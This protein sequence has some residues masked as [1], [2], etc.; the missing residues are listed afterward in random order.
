MTLDSLAKRRVAGTALDLPVFGFGSAHLGELYDKVDE[1]VATTTLNTAW[2]AGVRFYDTAPWYGRGLSEHRTG[3]FLR[4][5]PRDEFILTTKVGRTLYRP[6]DPKNFDRSPWTGG[7]NFAVRH[8]YSY[9]GIMRS[10]EQSLQRL[11]LDTVDALFLHD[12]DPLFF[13]PEIA[14]HYQAFD[15]GGFRAMAELKASG[16]VKAIGVGVNLSEMLE[17]MVR[18]YDF[19]LALVAMPYTLLDQACLQTGM[20]ACVL[21]G[22]SVVIGAPFASGILVTGSGAGAKYAYGAAA[23]EVQ[24]KVRGIEAVCRAHNVSLPAAALQFPL[25][26]PAVAA[27]IPGAARPA[28]VLANITS[29]DARIPAAFWA[30]L[31]SQGL[32]AADAPVPAGRVA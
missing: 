14:G 26:H 8:D 7:L 12:L 18:G 3:G 23:P 10:Y 13:G 15:S 2:D 31:R 21:R 16:H 9:D 28:E 20:A 1:A 24:A 11:A 29:L 4:A 6:D 32:I 25:A 5:K 17:R 30:D 27:I 19:D 22:T